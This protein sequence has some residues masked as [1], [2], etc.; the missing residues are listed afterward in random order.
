MDADRLA[1]YISRL[2]TSF[3][4]MAK[5]MTT[6]ATAFQSVAPG[7]MLSGSQRIVLRALVDQ[8]AHQVTEVANLLGVTLS[9][10]T[11]LV[12]RLVKSKLVVR[13]RDQNDRRVVWVKV[14]PE[15]EL[16][17]LAAEKRRRAAF[18]TMVQNLEEA[19]LAQLCDIL[20]RI[21]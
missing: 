10:A 7:P 14:T 11:G 5:I 21:Q 8:G 4:H 6:A 13:E 1:P 12:D 2:E 16:A 20:D 19:E 17:V 9:A 18:R 3:N 15:G